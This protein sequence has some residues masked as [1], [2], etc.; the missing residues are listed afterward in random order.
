MTCTAFAG[1]DLD[2]GLIAREHAQLLPKTELAHRDA[3]FAAA[4]AIV[5]DDAKRAAAGDPVSP[6][7]IADGWRVNS[8]LQRRLLF[9]D[10]DAERAVTVGYEEAGYRLELDGIA[11]PARAEAG[12]DDALVFILE[13]IR[14]VATVVTVGDRL[15]V[16]LDGRQHDL[17]RVDVLH[18]SGEENDSAD[19]LTAP[20]PA[21]VV[22]HLVEEG[23][24]VEKGAPLLVLEAMKME[25]T[26]VAPAAGKVRAFHFLTGVQV[27]AG[28]ELVDFEK[29]T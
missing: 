2:T 1:A 16:F 21:L 11:I 24:A 23:A 10:G 5:L 17:G 25:M 19:G 18:R 26:I 29:Q 8:R 14:R 28:A 9:R 20:I 3:C 13:E 15:H 27:P 4:L 7:A 6:W 12:S 22:A